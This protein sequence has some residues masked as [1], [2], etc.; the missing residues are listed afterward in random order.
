MKEKKRELE[1]D[2]HRLARLGVRLMVSTE[3]GIVVTNGAD[4]SLVSEVKEK[5]TKTLFFL[6][7][8]QVSIAK[9]YWLS[10]KGRWCADI[11][12]QIMYT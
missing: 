4:S 8:R 3:G 10:N 12:R 5:K 11:P 7:C 9:E 6:I 2:V 1:K